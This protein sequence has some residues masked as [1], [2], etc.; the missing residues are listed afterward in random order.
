MT[1]AG[2]RSPSTVCRRFCSGGSPLSGGGFLRRVGP[3]LFI[4]GLMVRLLSV[5]SLG[6]AAPEVREEVSVQVD[7]WGY[8]WLGMDMLESPQD[9]ASK[10][11]PLYGLFLGATGGFQDEGIMTT[12]LIQQFMDLASSLMVGAC[13][14]RF[15]KRAMLPAAGLT[16]LVPAGVIHSMMLLPESMMVMACAGSGYFW[17]RTVQAP[18]ARSRTMFACATGAALAAGTAVKPVIGLAWMVYA[19][20]VL[21]QRSFPWKTRLLVL[22]LLFVYAG[23]F[24]W[25]W[26]AHNQRNFGLDAL[27]TQTVRDPFERVLILSGEASWDR[28]ERNPQILELSMPALT[29]DGWDWAMRDSIYSSMMWRLIRE[30]PLRIALP[31]LISWP[32]FFKPGT[33]YFESLPVFH[34]R[35][36]AF[37]LLSGF[38]LLLALGVGALFL[39]A[40]ARRNIRN[41]GRPLLTMALAW[42]IFSALVSGPAARAPRYGL[43]FFWAFAAA[44]GVAVASLTDGKYLEG[45][46]PDAAI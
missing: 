15:H 41:R 4:L 16:L 38:S 7:S 42:F 2:G 10:R 28:A 40:W 17:I 36:V 12:V 5:L 1:A 35:P 34:D 11:L 27:S 32:G 13:A 43:T 31:H 46:R 24:G 9:S 20:L 14:A 26:R 18:D 33:R 23:S 25:A 8:R 39:V 22:A 44:G 21:L 6:T 3:G 29:E 37:M 19:V 30:R 45:G